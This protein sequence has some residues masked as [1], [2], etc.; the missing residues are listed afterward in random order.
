MNKKNILILIFFLQFI[1]YSQKDKRERLA[2]LDFKVIANETDSR[3]FKWLESGFAET[4]TDAFSRIPEFSTVERSQMSKILEEQNFQSRNIIDTS[5]IARV[6]KLLGVNSVIIGSCQLYTG[7]MMINM[8]M[9]NVETGE[10]QPLSNPII[11]PVNNVLELQ[12]EI[13]VAIL[14]K[15]NIVSD[16]RINDI[17]TVTTKSTKNFLAYEY[18]NKGI[19]FYNNRQ[20]REALLMFDKSLYEDKRYGKAFYKKGITN[21]ALNNFAEAANNFEKSD[22]YIK[23]DSIYVLMSN[24][25]LAA[26]DKQKSLDFLQKAKKLNPQNSNLDG[27]ILSL[28][29]SN[30]IVTDNEIQTTFEFKNGI[31]RVKGK[32]KYGYIDLDNKIVIPMKFD[33]LGDFSHGLAAA[34]INSKW[35]YINFRGDFIITP[36]Y[37]N[38]SPFDDFGLARV[39][40]K[41]KWGVIN[42]KGEI[43][44]PTD[45][46]INTFYSSWESEPL[47]TVAN[48]KG[49]LAVDI[50]YG[51][52]DR[53]GKQILPLEYERI[54]TP[55]V[56]DEK[57]NEIDYPFIHVAKNGKWGVVNK[58]NEIIIPFVYDSYESIKPFKNNYAA[59]KVNEKWGFVDLKG[60]IVIEPIF[61]RVEDYTPPFIIVKNR[62]KWGAINI[63][64]VEIL[65]CDYSKI[66]YLE[67]GFW[68]A[69]KNGVW[70]LLDSTNKEICPFVY[71]KMGESVGSYTMYLTE[72]FE[73]NILKV[74]VV[75]E[76]KKY[77][78][79]EKC[80]CISECK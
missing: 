55:R 25:F 36:N 43:I 76:K 57:Y 4:L 48:Y 20:Y 5:S 45:F 34:K 19:T 15:Y 23:K 17:T 70:G 1:C 50:V 3:D 47:M 64:G 18:L 14:S 68:A 40:I 38:V 21:L 26:G 28:K 60:M 12:K 27:K 13:C 10:I 33:D 65:P 61:E 71:E 46:L 69:K 24:A 56:L 30:E 22:K 6:G 49:L 72:K 11:G 7:H 58:L 73:K 9:V 54:Y 41:E 75:K 16:Q 66:D 8:R 53:T 74:P 80:Q 42:S 67:K 35:G 78:I 37:T 79:N 62:E 52:Y 32:S 51:A 31:A 44:I 77:W 29:N 63:E 39:E 59:V 2:I